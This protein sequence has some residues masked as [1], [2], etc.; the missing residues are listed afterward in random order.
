YISSA[1]TGLTLWLVPSASDSA[2]LKNI[3]DTRP[4]SQSNSEASYPQF[5][6][7]ITLASFPDP[8]PSLAAIL[9]SISQAQPA[10][11]VTFDAVEVGDHFF[12]SVYLAVHP[13]PALLD[14][15]RHVHAKLEIPPK[16]PKY[17]HISLCYISDE[18]A[19][20]GERAK[21]FQELQDSG[22]IRE[23]GNSISLNCGGL[24]EEDW[25]SGF[26]SPEIWVTRCEGPV[27]T[28]TVEQKIALQPLL[29][30]EK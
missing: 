15:H 11:P 1:A 2:R 29:H 24:S 8:A 7:H 26:E 20:S 30:T 16:T 14:L 23:N 18:D 19:A 4:K 21:Y 5:Q 9:S 10:L 17:P 3:M 28:W 6:P 22:K 12:R 27:E 13:T 25:F